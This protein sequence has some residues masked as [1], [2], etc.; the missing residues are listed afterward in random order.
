MRGASSSRSFDD[1]VGAGGEHRCDLDAEGFRSLEIDKELELR[2]LHGGKIGG[3][4]AL[5]NASGI[6]AALSKSIGQT[7]SVACQAAKRD[8]IAPFIDCRHHIPRC[9]CD[10]LFTTTVKERI[11]GNLK[12]AGPQLQTRRE[13]RFYVA[14]AAGVED[15]ELEPE[16]TRSLGNLVCL[17]ACI[18]LAR[19]YQCCDHGR[20][21]N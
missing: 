18:R 5:E 4:S 11:G 19:I 14:L 20:A 10:D 2:R 17:G 7:G 16:H 12:R 6:D 9:Q 13:G 15:M 8:E 1:L 21:R 3:L